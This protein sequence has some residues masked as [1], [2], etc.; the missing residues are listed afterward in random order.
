[1]I[2]RHRDGEL[3]LYEHGYSGVTKYIEILFA[4]ANLSGPMG[5][6]QTEELL[7]LDRGL[8]DSNAHYVEGGDAPRLEPL[9]LTF[10]CR[11]ADTKNTQLLLQMAA[12]V[13]DHLVVGGTTY[14][15]NSRKGKGIALYGF[16]TA[17]PNFKDTAFKMCWM[18]ETLWSG[19]S[20]WGM[21]WDEVYFPPDQQTITESEDSLTLTL[22]GMVYGG[23]TTIVAFNAGDAMV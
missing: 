9:T 22:N 8:L 4:D 21:R 19:T 13:T 10:S 1:M 14:Q 2:F 20:D 16:T 6:P 11:S 5:R 18:V 3:R 17:A 12:G 7:I 15:I 23:V